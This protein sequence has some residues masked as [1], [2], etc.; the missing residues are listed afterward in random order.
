MIGGG[1]YRVMGTRRE[2]DTL[3]VELKQ[4]AVPMYDARDLDRLLAA[5]TSDPSAD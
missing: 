3:I 1:G 4:L 2:G 5:S